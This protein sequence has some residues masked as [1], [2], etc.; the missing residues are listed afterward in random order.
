MTV[1]VG[2]IPTPEGEA[3][4]DTAIREA[5]ARSVPLVVINTSRD[6]I[7]ADARRLHPDGA[8]ELR[9]RLAGAIVPVEVV[10]R[11]RPRQAA[12]E[13]LEEIEDRQPSLVVI[14]LRRRSAVGKLILGS[15]AQRVLLEARC[16][17][18]AVKP[19]I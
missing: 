2:Y 1:L 12:D 18:L 15:T 13:L 9:S 14:G 10:Q 19:T 11:Q 6:D 7:P 4:L 17:V 3:A 5:E 8:T 16:P